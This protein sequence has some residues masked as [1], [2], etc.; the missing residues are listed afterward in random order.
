L[1]PEPKPEKLAKLKEEHERRLDLLTK[2]ARTIIRKFLNRNF[3]Y[4]P[5][6]HLRGSH[7]ENKDDPERVPKNDAI[8]NACA[9][10]ERA[11]VIESKLQQHPDRFFQYLRQHMLAS[12]QAAVE[13]TTTIR[14]TIGVLLN[15]DLDAEDKQGILIKKY[16]AL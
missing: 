15:S 13:A 3:N 4:N 2:T 6:H 11:P 8:R 12:Y 7:S 1:G 14:A 9:T 16:K 10:S 5:D